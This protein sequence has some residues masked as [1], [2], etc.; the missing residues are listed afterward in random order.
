M[1][2]VLGYL[3]SDASKPVVEIHGV[4]DASSG[5]V[6]AAAVSTHHRCDY[7]TCEDDEQN[8]GDED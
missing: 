1:K 5:A 4:P 3:D 2:Q 6:L 7:W 8:E